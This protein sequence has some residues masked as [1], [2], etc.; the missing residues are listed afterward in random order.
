[1][2]DILFDE[3]AETL[4]KLLRKF[5]TRMTLFQQNIAHSLGVFHTDLKCAD[6]INETGPINPSELAKE[7]GL[8][9]GTVTTLIDRLVD[10]GYVTRQRDPNDRRKVFICANKEEQ[11]KI[12]DLYIPL[13]KSIAQLCDRY[14]D[15][16]LKSIFDFMHQ[17]TKIVQIETGH[18][19]DAVEKDKH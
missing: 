15:E 14:S 16:E 4:I 9:T 11:S 10:A 18:M 19:K 5:S 7:S 3:Q 6:I 8:T 17:V 2:S 13:A 1:M 12:K